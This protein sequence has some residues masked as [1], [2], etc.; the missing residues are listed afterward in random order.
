MKLSARS[1]SLHCVRRRVSTHRKSAAMEFFFCCR[2]GEHGAHRRRQTRRCC[3]RHAHFAVNWEK[4]A[5]SSHYTATKYPYVHGYFVASLPH[6][7]ETGSVYVCIRKS[8]ELRS[9]HCTWKGRW[10]YAPTRVFVRSVNGP[11][12]RCERSLTE[13]NRQD[14]IVSCS[15]V[16]AMG[17]SKQ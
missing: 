7:N 8:T 2:R 13:L 1:W 10:H 4:E 11:L 5:F 14:G 16:S 6:F 17:T 15:S 3:G 9:M 12:V